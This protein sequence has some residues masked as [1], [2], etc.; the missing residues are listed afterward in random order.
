MPKK[1]I[2]QI[3]TLVH[4]TSFECTITV[5]GAV[6]GFQQGQLKV[7]LV[8]RAIEPFKDYWMLPGGIMKA[9]HSVEE[10]MNDVLFHLTGINNIH[11]EQVKVYSKINR[12]PV[13]R[14]VTV[15][16]YALVKPENHPVI[17]KNYISDV[18]WFT[19]EEVPD[20]GFDHN[21][22]LED[23]LMQLR[24]N[25]R[26]HLLVGELLPKKFTLKELQDLY[27]SILG[28]SL[29]RRNFRKKMMQLDLIQSTG[30]KKIGI[31]GG[32]ELFTMK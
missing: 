23:A 8:K 17:A 31:K 15:T 21:Q 20:L 27:E 26:D 1:E 6:F 18:K 13:K 32:P 2:N 9:D 28:E 14:V 10:A 4:E 5:D 22:I 19:M 24:H 11:T 30:E 3:S 25:L 7:L 29:D 16:F 12:H